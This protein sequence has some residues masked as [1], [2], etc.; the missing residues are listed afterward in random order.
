MARYTLKEIFNMM[1]AVFQ[2]AFGGLQYG[3]LA[4][5][6]A[7]LGRKLRV[8]EEDI[9]LTDGVADTA[10]AHTPLLFQDIQD[11]ATNPATFKVYWA[12]GTTV[13]TGSCEYDAAD[14]LLR[15]L[16]N[17]DPPGDNPTSPVTVRYLAL[18]ADLSNDVTGDDAYHAANPG[19][20]GPLDQS[21]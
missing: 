10:L 16:C 18:D 17:A 11:G 21:V 13:P 7:L 5:F 4:G 9:E 20:A 1:N 6:G 15:F 8:Y 19:S 2:E 14:G 12:T 3:D